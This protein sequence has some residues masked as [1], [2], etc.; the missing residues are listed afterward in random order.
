MP[1]PLLEDETLAL[2]RE[3]TEGWNLCDHCLG[4][5]VWKTETGMGNPARAQ[6]V[7]EE[8]SIEETRLADCYLC[9]GIFRDADLFA[10]VTIEALENWE[11]DSYL[12]GT[13]V[14]D[15]IELREEGIWEELDL[16]DTES[17]SSEL[18]RL[19]GKQVGRHYSEATFDHE[20][21]DAAAIV[22]TR[23][24][25][26]TVEAKPLFLFGRYRK[27]ERGIPQT[28]WPCSE[29][30]GSGC[31]AC[32][33]TGKQYPTSVEELVAGPVVEAAEAEEQS[34]HGAGR[35]DV[36]A[37]MLGEGR[38]F[39]LEL[40][41][42]RVRSVAASDLEKRMND[43][44][45]AEGRVEVEGLRW[46]VRDEVAY[47][48]E[49]SGAKTYRAEVELGGGVPEE[50]FKN[51]VRGLEGPVDQRTPTR[52]SH[53]RADKVRSR[54]VLHAEVVEWD[55]SRAVIRVEGEAGLYVKELV[56]GDESRTTP[57]LAGEL[58]VDAEVVGLDVEAVDYTPPADLVADAGAR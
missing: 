56:S 38:P 20:D 48:K 5:L 31:E 9:A 22:D 51:V 24:A 52:V 45:E 21:P 58:G 1:R 13:K 44:A 57:S 6:V 18:N 16:E 36:D 49:H 55:E 11:F 43:A 47:L 15:D 46:T 42:P 2:V 40:N 32:D 54:D 37:R 23:F 3:A 19:V 4:R 7:R 10:E 12:V 17:V 29:C 8:L 27:L 50:R 53:R 14:A 35:E 34:F 26:V 33:R 25:D 30:R 41:Q 28:Y 39:V